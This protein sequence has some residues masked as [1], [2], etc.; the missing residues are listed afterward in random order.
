MKTLLFLFLI[1]FSLLCQTYKSIIDEV[2]LDS[3]VFNV[4]ILSREKP[5]PHYGLIVDRSSQIGREITANYLYSRLLSFGL[6]VELDNYS[7]IGNNVIATKIGRKYPDSIFII[8]AHYD[9]VERHCADDN[10]SGTSAVLEAARIISKYSP[11]YTVIFALW[12]EEEVGLKGSKDYAKNATENKE[13]I[14]GVLNLDMIGYDSNDD[15]LFEVHHNNKPESIRLFNAF[16]SIYQNSSAF[17]LDMRELSNGNSN[18]DQ[19]SFWRNNYGAIH[20]I[21][22]YNSNDFNPNYHT[23]ADRLKEFNLEYFHKLSA[24]SIE[25]LAKLAVLDLPTNLNELSNKSIIEVYPNPTIDYVYY[26]DF[27]NKISK[28]EIFDSKGLEMLSQNGLNIKSSDLS[29]LA[30]G[31]YTLVITTNEKLIHHQ[32]IK[33]N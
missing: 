24:L 33:L 18:S 9:A 32:L 14:L 21:E 31:V 16:N 8:S 19:A 28:I 10:A 30:S 17:S 4:E 7:E 11:E 15:G 23:S 29:Y 27:E 2:D 12:D 3:L 13:N 20:I 1:P 25:T 5:I 6:D 22:A 26:N